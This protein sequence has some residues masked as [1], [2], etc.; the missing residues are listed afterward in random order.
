M[1]DFQQQQY[2]FAAHIRDPQ[3]SPAPAGVEDRRMAIYRELFYNNVEG[4]M[5]DSFPVLR[6]LL[7]DEKWHRLIRDYFARHRATT[8]L[9]PEMPREFLHYLEHERTAEADDP[10]F[11]FELAHYEWVE[12]AL[13]LSEQEPD[14]SRIDPEGHLLKGR[15]LLSP[16]AWPLSYHY[17]VQLIGPDFRPD[18][19]GEQ[20]TW[21]LVYRDA[22]DEITFM[23]LN[24]V[25]A[26]LL[27]LIDNS[28]LAS[29][30]AM[31]EQIATEL[32]HPEPAVVIEGGR[33]ILND[34][35]Q[36]GVIPGT[37]LAG[38]TPDN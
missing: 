5:A 12:L 15:P 24:P 14:W 35:H 20:P 27:A 1:T 32:N 8:P 30:E 9:F 26:R 22:R 2:R 4:F 7:D 17:P 28:E 31:L 34:L 38:N 37:R 16:L 23:E 3:A 36:R 19:P 21:L 11:L 25:T 13:S 10:P 6:R 33:Q 18:Q 29:G